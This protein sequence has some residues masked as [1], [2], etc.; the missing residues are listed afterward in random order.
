MAEFKI[1]GGRAKGTPLTAAESKDIEYWAE[2]ISGD[3]EKDPDKKFAERDRAWLVAADAEL[4]RRA[5]GGAKEA[6]APADDYSTY[7]DEAAAGDREERERRARQGTAVT[8]TSSSLMGSF[9]DPQKATAA[10]EEMAKN[11]HLITPAT[12][13]GSIPEGCE[14]Q[15]SMVQIP[16]D[17]PHL[18]S[19]AGGKFGIDRVH[20]LSILGAAGGSIEYTRRLDTGSH[21][22]YCRMEVG[23][24]YRLFDGTP[25]RRSGTAEMDVRAPDGPRYVEIV[26]KA[27]AANRSPDKQLLE[28]R[29]FLLPH[30]E[31]R[32]LN[33]AIAA[34]GVRR[35]YTKQELG[36]PFA[37]ARL[38]F[39]GR[40]EDPEARREFRAAI[41]QSFLQGQTALYGGPQQQPPAPP[42]AQLHEPPPVGSGYDV[43][44]T[45]EEY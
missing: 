6:A 42:A 38:F 35:S 11:Y 15:V 27:K 2:R 28:M 23:I 19:L 32:A 40:S 33:R 31:S 7:V 30:T 37:V 3:L 12:A 22:H 34:M 39:S 41:A 4:D 21:P 44:A 17:D 5:K 18:Y 8:R 36:K 14:V 9:V 20:L 45:G 13:C 25:V 26:E 16:P 24:V 1:P 43:E 29:K 10:L